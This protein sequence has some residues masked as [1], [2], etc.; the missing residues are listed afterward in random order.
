[1]IHVY[2][3]DGK[4]KTTAAV[5]LAVRHAG[6]G[7]RVLFVQFMKCPPT[8]EIPCLEELPGIT[9]LRNT[10]H[11]G[12]S[13]AMTEEERAS[14][15]Q[16]H[17][18]NLEKARQA[19]KDGACTL[20]VLDEAASA[21]ELELLDREALQALVREIGGVELVL[22]GRNPAPFMLDAADYVTEMKALKHPYSRGISAR[23]GV[24]Y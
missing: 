2:C 12:F 20:L 21:Y 8:G 13:F 10:C 6:C 11:H 22:T 24:E 14:V 7:G 5:G 15:R 4:G 3:G 1:M 16:N 19:V 9:V 18:Q 23:K 17:D